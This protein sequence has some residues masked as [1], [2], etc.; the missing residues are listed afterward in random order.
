MFQGNFS[1][2]LRAFQGCF[3]SFLAD[4]KTHFCVETMN[5]SWYNEPK[6]INFRLDRIRIKLIGNQ[7]SHLYANS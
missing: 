1:G 2:V 3:K 5:L 6:K 7:H 4:N